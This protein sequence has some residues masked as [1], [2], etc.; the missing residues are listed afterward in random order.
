MLK[1]IRIFLAGLIFSICLYSC[2]LPSGEKNQSGP[3]IPENMNYDTSLKFQQY[4]TQGRMLYKRNCI[5]C[6][7]NSGAGMKQLI[8]PLA[9]SDYLADTAAVACI[10][11]HGQQGEIIVN[12]QK[13]EGI[14]PANPQLKPL[15]IAE[16]VTYIRNSWG[17]EGG[18][19]SVKD[20]ER[21]LNLC[22][23]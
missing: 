17:N 16:L 19:T 5:N 13:F 23:K 21:Y 15:E 2:D 18:F 9:G 22:D 3:P 4:W 14:M 7:Q 1:L 8:P 11:L 20:A 10:I 6:H 12:G